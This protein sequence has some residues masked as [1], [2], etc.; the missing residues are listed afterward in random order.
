MKRY[1]IECNHVFLDD[2]DERFHGVVHNYEE[3]HIGGKNG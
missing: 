2:D 1:C 3:F